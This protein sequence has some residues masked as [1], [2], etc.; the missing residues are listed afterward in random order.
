MRNLLE[1]ENLGKRYGSFA[2][3]GVNLSVAPGSVCG[4]IGSNGAGKTTIIKAALG[5]ISADEGSVSLFDERIEP[6]SATA[7]I[8]QRVGVVLDVCAFPADCRVAD[9]ERIG[10]AAFP[11]WRR[12]TWNNLTARFALKPKQK[13]G[14]LSRGMGM[15]LSLAFALAHDPQLLLLDEATAGLDPLAR[16]EALDLLREFMAGEDRGILMSTHITTDLE[17]IADEVICIDGGKQVFTA[18]KEA[19]TDE[20]GI[21]RCRAADL[22]AVRAQARASLSQSELWCVQGAYGADVLVPDRFA[23]ARAFPDVAVDRAT[24]EEYMALRLKGELL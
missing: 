9:V 11:A 23:F 10:R 16:D 20:A 21:A 7:R 24:I 22:D 5:L 6:S 12:E 2:L 4:L 13:V 8:K 19:I 1:L 18:T 15:K 14:K 3:Q 17:K